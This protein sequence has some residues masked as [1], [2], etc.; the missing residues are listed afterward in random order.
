VYAP[1]CDDAVDAVGFNITLQ[2]LV[3]RESA[4]VCNSAP[5]QQTGFNQAKTPTNWKDVDLRAFFFRLLLPYCRSGT[6]KWR[7]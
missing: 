2:A 5:V 4:I 6:V 1:V 7:K 3:E